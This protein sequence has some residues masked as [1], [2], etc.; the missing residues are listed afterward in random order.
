MKKEIQIRN[1][2]DDLQH[3]ATF[4]EEIADELQLSPELTMNF[5]LVLEEMVSNV[6]FYAYPKENDQPI[7]LTATSDDESISFIITD[8]GRAFDPTAREDADMSVNPA[9]RQLGGMGIFI[10]RQIMDDVTYQRINGC[11]ILTMT[12]RL[13]D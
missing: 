1:Q 4:V 3:V 13:K 11:N 5:N 10:T 7:I 8:E 12:K 2:V 6:I 9:D